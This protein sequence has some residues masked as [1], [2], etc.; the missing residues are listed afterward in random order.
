[1]ESKYLLLE[2]INTFNNMLDIIKNKQDKPFI[3]KQCKDF[4]FGLD[5]LLNSFL[6]EKKDTI[7]GYTDINKI[8]YENIDMNILITNWFSDKLTHILVDTEC[9]NEKLLPEVLKQDIPFNKCYTL[10]KQNNLTEFHIGPDYGSGWMYLKLGT[11]KWWFIS[12]FDM[13]YLNQHGI[14]IDDLKEKNINELLLLC[15]NYL[16]GKIYVGE[17]NKN[18]FIFFPKNWALRVFTSEKSIGISGYCDVDMIA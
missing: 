18:D 9:T 3:I 8:E 4:T 17:I 11:K 5:D 13:E 16:D 12:P 14:T 15:D 2:N 6:S 10:T 7:W 1:M